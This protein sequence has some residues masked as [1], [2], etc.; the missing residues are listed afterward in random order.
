MLVSKYDK[1]SS[2][3]QK[4][5]KGQGDHYLKTPGI[6]WKTNVRPG[7]AGKLLKKNQNQAI[8]ILGIVLSNELTDFQIFVFLLFRNTIKLH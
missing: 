4:S 7:K 5:E 6:T 8:V 1:T 3:F 2:N